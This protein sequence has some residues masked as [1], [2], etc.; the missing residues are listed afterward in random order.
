MDEIGIVVIA[1]N[2][3][4]R[5]Q[6]CIRSLL[7]L[8]KK[9]V[10]VDSGS[11]DGSQVWV[12]A[13][14]IAIVEL[15]LQL[16]FTA[17]RAR[18]A[19]WEHL[20]NLYPEISYVQFVDGDCEVQANWLLD[21]KSILVNH[22]K[23]G[24]VC[25]RRRERY[26]DRTIYNALCDIEWNTPIGETKAA[27]GDV[28]MRASV[29]QAVSGYNPTV[30]AAEDD[31]ICLRIRRTGQQIWRIDSEMT[32]HDA[33][34]YRFHQWFKRAVRAGY[35]YALGNWLHGSGPEKQFRKEIRRIWRT[36]FLLPLLASALAW[37]TWGISLIF[38]LYY[39]LQ[40]VRIAQRTR[41]RGY[42]IK[43]SLA[44]G[45]SCILDKLPQL[46]GVLKFHRNRLFSRQATIIEYK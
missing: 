27:G 7:P 37:P 23:V 18:N 41:K 5:L 24:A 38:L 28:M 26:P 40:V 19:G 13:Q 2:E 45:I 8:T 31:E 39:P 14:G 11:T 32:I 25:G 44:W 36:A 17:A 6:A 21:A 35:A 3:G 34:M 30:I 20:L 16:P 4:A 15:D 29:L 22:P 10:Y 33:A 1:R 42:S 46:I 9:I 43:I 12:T